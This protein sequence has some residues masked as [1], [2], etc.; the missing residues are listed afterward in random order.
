MRCRLR[1]KYD[2]VPKVAYHNSAFKITS[3]YTFL[4]FVGNVQTGW[5]DTSGVLWFTYQHI[6][7]IRKINGCYK[8]MRHRGCTYSTMSAPIDLACT[9]RTSSLCSYTCMYRNL[10]TSTNEHLPIGSSVFSDVV[11][12]AMLPYR[13]E[14]MVLVWKR[15]TI[16]CVIVLSVWRSLYECK[17]LCIAIFKARLI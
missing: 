10:W 13:S 2:G 7:F 11:I 3:T 14:H 16:F 12:T 1:A 5:D 17:L 6:D 9:R 8:D 4:Q 15:S